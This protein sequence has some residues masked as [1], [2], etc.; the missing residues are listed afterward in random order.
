MLLVHDKVKMVEMA[1]GG[2]CLFPHFFRKN[3]VK[4]RCK[5]KILPGAEPIQHKQA[6]YVYQKRTHQPCSHH[7][8]G[9]GNAGYR[10]DAGKKTDQGRENAKEDRNSSYSPFSPRSF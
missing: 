3:T 7:E 10:A 1:L 4:F 6:W 2:I 8:S 9:Y 5:E